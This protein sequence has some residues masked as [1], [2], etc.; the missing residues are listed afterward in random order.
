MTFYSTR[1]LKTETNKLL[2]ELSEGKYVVITEKGKPSA[3]LVSI[4]E[5]HF[6]ETLLALRQVKGREKAIVS[7]K[8]VLPPGIERTTSLKQERMVAIRDKTHFL[9]ISPPL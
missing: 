5:G 8:L 7:P 4:P 9:H 1:D 6:D 3:F 2:N